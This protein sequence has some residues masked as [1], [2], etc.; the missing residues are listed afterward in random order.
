MSEENKIR[1]FLIGIVDGSLSNHLA[2]EL[3]KRLEGYPICKISMSNYLK[4]GAKNETI[5]ESIDFELLVS[6][7]SKLLNNEECQVPI[8]DFKTR[9][10]KNEIKKIEPCQI[11]ILEGLLCFYDD[12]IR[13]MMDLKLFIETGNDIRFI[14]TILK[15][16]ENDNNANLNEIMDKYFGEIKP[17]YNN[18][19]ATKKYADIILPNDTGHETGINIIMNYLKLLLDRV[20]NQKGNLF[21][22]I[23][24]IIDSKYEFCADNLILKKEKS[25][26]DFLRAIFEDLIKVRQDK[27]FVDIIRKTLLDMIE[28]LLIDYFQKFTEIKLVFDSDDISN[29]DFKH[30]STVFFY[31]TAILTSKDIEK[32]KYILSK[33]KDCNIIICSIFLAPRFAHLLIGKQMNSIL[34]ATLYFSEFF[35]KYEKIIKSDK[36]VFNEEELKR[37]VNQMLSK[38]LILD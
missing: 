8:Y 20:R 25:T 18:F 5:P 6:N 17:S 21:F 12:S 32:P 34:F 38:R 9:K 1:P 26:I 36:M 27:E 22:F 31:K 35:V 29:Y 10:R 28:S 24:E 15:E 11:I 14:E 23:N 3:D 4:D 7:L 33:N 16:K 19:I 2:Q 13:N 37:M 30:C